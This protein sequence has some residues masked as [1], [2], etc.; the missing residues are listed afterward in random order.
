MSSSKGKAD[1][2]IREKIIIPKGNKILSHS[3][4]TKL[5]GAHSGMAKTKTV[6]TI[7]INTNNIPRSK[8]A[9][10]LIPRNTNHAATAKKINP[11]TNSD[12]KTL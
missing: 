7:P 9:I 4:V 10:L 2:P 1:E 8:C 11:Q 12:V 5:C 6:T 3:T